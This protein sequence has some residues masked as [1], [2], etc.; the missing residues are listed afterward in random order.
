[1]GKIFDR[2]K[3]SARQLRTVAERRL[4]DAQY[5]RDSNSNARANGV[6]YLGG[7]VLECLL[8]AMLIE[9]YPSLL[10][11]QDVSKLSRTD[12]IVWGLIFRSHE[13]DVMISYLPGL[14]R[15]L[16]TRYADGRDLLGDLRR[17]C[18][19]WT[20]YARY[21]SQT[22]TMDNAAAFLRT[23]REIKQWLN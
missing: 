19:Q 10:S 13:L 11:I 4:G 12:R 23:I 1:M 2:Q 9:A 17:I 6:F 8:K 18:G 20:I 14:T 5:L 16:A 21:S 15:K 7:F 22:E 3:L